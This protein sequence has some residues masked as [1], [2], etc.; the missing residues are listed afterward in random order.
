MAGIEQQAATTAEAANEEAIRAWDGPLFDRFLRFQHVI[1][2]GLG[3]HGDAA[4]E[5]L[6]P[7]PG[8]RAID[9][10]CGFGDTTE[11]IAEIVGPGGQALG[12]DAAP[13][14]IEY[15]RETSERN[16]VANAGFD[17]A[18]VQTMELGDSFDVAFARFGTM[19]FANPV[20]AMRNVRR[21]LRPGGR[22]A[23]TV[24]RR[25]EDNE[26]L[27]RA[28]TIVEGIVSRPEEYDEPTCG[29]GPFSMADA[30]T[31]STHMQSAGFVDVALQRCD[32]R[33]LVGRDLDDA[34][35]LVMALGPAG[36]ILRLAG[37]RAAHLHGRVDEALREGLAELVEDDGVF[38]LSSSWLVTARV[39]D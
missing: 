19:F 38:A 22:L 29:P 36:E 17:V 7:Q 8:E 21:T 16:G 32:L 9:I 30:D 15:A 37:D 2:G 13:R 28:Q 14:F 34:I 3:Q 6:A 18:D 33:T 5:L 39:P 11:R 31:T 24:W 26:W 20:A 4:L 35:D 12:I 27:Y 1:V 23:M 10:G 25:R